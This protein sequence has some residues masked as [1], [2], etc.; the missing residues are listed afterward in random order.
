M[1]TIRL[2]R[3]TGITVLALYSLSTTT[4]AFSNT[5]YIV[6]PGDTLCEIAERFEVRCADLMAR[7]G[8]EKASLIYPGQVLSI[9]SAAA[10]PSKDPDAEATADAEP[11]PTPA[12]AQSTTEPVDKVPTPRSRLPEPTF[13]RS[14]R[15]RVPAIRSSPPKPSAATRLRRPYLRPKRHCGLR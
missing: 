1:D 2:L 7:K 11:E 8:L 3:K 15:R 4:P 13:S 6:Q 9:S 12:V 10:T 14:T 5:D